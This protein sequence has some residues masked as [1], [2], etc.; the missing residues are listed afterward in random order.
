MKVLIYVEGGGAQGS[1]KTNCR[2]A[3]TAFFQKV[4]PPGSFKVIASGSRSDA[5][6]NF[7]TTLKTN[8][9]DYIVLLV[10]SEE[11]VTTGP[12]QHLAARKGDK[13][14]RPA[15]A[16]SDQAH[17][18]VQAMESWFLAD[19]NVLALYYGQGFLVNSL[20]VQSNIELIPKKTVFNA[21]RHATKNTQKG[22][23]HKTRHS[24][25][26]LEQIE[27]ARVRTASPHAKRLLTVLARET[28]R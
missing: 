22:K 16:H 24:F 8:R 18:M 9:S 12:W 2:I 28:S 14:R 26:L 11:R 17:L 10:D 1:T 25:D 7:C 15:N 27:P 5:Y 4:I 3:F 23:Y 13:W 21:L 19:Q 6:K 20:P